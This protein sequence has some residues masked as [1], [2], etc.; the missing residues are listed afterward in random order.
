MIASVMAAGVGLG[1]LTAAAWSING[2][3][4]TAAAALR[5]ARLAPAPPYAGF[6]LDLVYAVRYLPCL[7]CGRLHLPHEV[8]DRARTARCV[9]C[10]A[11]RPLAA[12]ETPC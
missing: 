5:K 7:P 9:E 6:D 1:G 8:D 12:E 11:T 2:R 10:Q 3:L 4:I